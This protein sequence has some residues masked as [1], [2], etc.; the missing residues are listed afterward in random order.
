MMTARAGLLLLVLVAALDSQSILYT[1][2]AEDPSV[3]LPGVVDLTPDNF[4]ALVG[5]QKSALVEFYA[6]VRRIAL[7]M[8][9]YHESIDKPRVYVTAGCEGWGEVGGGD[10]VE[11]VRS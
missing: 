3:S 10:K 7:R 5:G 11:G 4:D 6:P 1:A 9:A 8:H 2:A